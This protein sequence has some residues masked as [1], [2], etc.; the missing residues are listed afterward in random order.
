MSAAEK[1]ASG[2]PR[3][4]KGHRGLPFK[5]KHVDRITDAKKSPLEDW[6]HRRRLYLGLQVARI[7]VLVVAVAILWLTHNLALAAAIAAISVPLPWVAVMLANESGEATKE[8]EKV[9]K[10]AIVRE[11]RAAQAR[12]Q[13]ARQNATQI[14]SAWHTPELDAGEQQLNS[15]H[16]VVD[17]D[18]LE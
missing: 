13:I 17:H 9:Y 15:S 1:R 4:P 11:N 6:H 8:S 5:H 12:A 2:S 16:E 14:G 7:P 18:A 10:P 3:K